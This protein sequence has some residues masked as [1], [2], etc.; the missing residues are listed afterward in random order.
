[1]FSTCFDKKHNYPVILLFHVLW[2]SNVKCF[3]ILH[4]RLIFTF[5]MVEC[6][7]RCNISVLFL[8]VISGKVKKTLFFPG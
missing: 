6:V 1:M 8:L 2:Y 7:L 4:Y 5:K 3:H